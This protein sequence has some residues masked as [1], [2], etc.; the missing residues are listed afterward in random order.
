MNYYDWNE[1]TQQCRK[2]QWK[3]TGSEAKMGESFRDGAEYHCPKCDNYFGFIA[4]PLTS[5]VK[6]DPR[7]AEIDRK[8]TALFEDASR[9][10]AKMALTSVTQL[11]DLEPGP[12][13]LIW[14]VIYGEKPFDD[15]YIV[16]LHGDQEIWRKM[17]FFEEYERYR[18]IVAILWEKYGE[19][20]R[21]VE[22]TQRSW[23]N[24][25]GDRLGSIGIVEIVRERLSRG[26]RPN[27]NR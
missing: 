3:G 21:D 25:G 9:R 20:L 26:E 17:S 1:G 19:T 4:Y 22:P 16:I 24:L 7:A 6:S 27:T 2:C 18:E 15:S 14:D 10:A 12:T 11:P 13:T 5:E 8:A 23:L